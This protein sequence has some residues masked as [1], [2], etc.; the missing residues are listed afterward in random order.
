LPLPGQWD[1]TLSAS[2]GNSAMAVTRR[3]IV[4]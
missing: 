4:R 1:V 3:V 2:V